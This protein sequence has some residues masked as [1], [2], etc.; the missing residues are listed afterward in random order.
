[1]G[2]IVINVKQLTQWYLQNNITHL[3][4][5]F[6]GFVMV[7]AFISNLITK[8]LNVPTVVGYIIIGAV[9][10]TSI[11]SRLTFLPSD[12]IDYYKLILRNFDYIAYVTLNFVAFM[13][14]LDLSVR[15][16]RTLGKSIIIMSLLEAFGA[17]FLVMFASMWLGGLPFY[18]AL[19]L[20]ALAAATAPP[21][22]VMVIQSLHSKGPL[23]STILA[24][25]GFDD[26][27]SLIIYSFASP[28]A[29]NFVVSGHHFSVFAAL[30]IPIIKIVIS[31]VIGGLGGYFAIKLLQKNRSKQDKVIIIFMLIFGISA[32][33]SYFDLSQLL[34][35][36][37]AGFVVRN[38]AKHY[39]GLS[40]VFDIIMV[41]L[42]AVFFILSG[43]KLDITLITN[44]TFLILS[45]IYLV[46]RIIG[47]ISGTSVGAAISK[48][49][50]SVRKYTG[51]GL[52]SQV[53]VALA[54]AYIIEQEFI[55]VPEFGI[56]VFNLLLFTTFFTETLGPILLKIVLIKSGE[57][58]TTPQP[59]AHKS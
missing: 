3:I 40:E 20:G 29:K 9:F 24:I 49:P 17:F 45:L 44:G 52:L 42:Y 15:V 57:A 22:T 14:G 2:N 48:A 38:M 59:A 43:I 11:V 50:A 18:Q 54:L 32:I 41:P 37:A 25:V 1:M 16:V 28:I 31:F 7:I 30:I 51:F 55:S 33:A 47:K 39:L 58:N 35:N 8:K 27:I 19:I 53:G 10:S 5:I 26:A 56:L 46:A 36:M 13:I 6:L 34:T 12:F 23:T 4:I 21:A